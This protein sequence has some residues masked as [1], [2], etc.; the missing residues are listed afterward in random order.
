MDETIY[1]VNW[2]VGAHIPFSKTIEPTILTGINCGMYT[3]QFFMGSPQSIRRQRISD[4]DIENTKELIKHF[5]M[6]IYTHFPYVANFAGKSAPDG[7]A[8][9]GNTQVDGYLK[10]I[11]AELEYELGVMA[12][13]GKGVVIHPGANP[14]RKEG[15]LAIAKTINKLSFPDNSTVILENCAGEGNKLCKDFNEI[16][17]ILDNIDEKQKSHVKVCVDT[18]HI[19]GQGDYDISKIEEVDRMFA[20]FD[21]IIGF[22]YFYLLHLNDSE[23]KLGAKKDRH[24]CLGEGEIWGKSFNSLIYLLDKCKGMNIPAVL[25]TNGNDMLTLSQLSEEDD[26]LVCMECT[27]IPVIQRCPCCLVR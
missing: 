17:V 18:A 19:W 12:K 25:E 14:K 21:S 4:E 26:G 6:H 10:V 27:S 23:V 2:E 22:D 7:L 20:E 24:A 15:L 5:P 8:W 3:L 9:S 16:K 13:V 11:M 1:T